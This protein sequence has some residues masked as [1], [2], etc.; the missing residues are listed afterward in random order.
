[1]D[2]RTDEDRILQEVEYILWLLSF[3]KEDNDDIEEKG[4]DNFTLTNEDDLI[5]YTEEENKALNCCIKDG[6]TSG[7]EDDQ[8]HVYSLEK[9]MSFPSLFKLCCDIQ[10]LRLVVITN[11]KQ[12]R[13]ILQL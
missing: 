1:M 6:C 13:V 12:L 2:T 8:V 11:T 9:L 7:T 3:T 5:D 4:S 10:R